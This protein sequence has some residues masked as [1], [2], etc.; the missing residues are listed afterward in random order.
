MLPPVDVRVAICGFVWKKWINRPPGTL[1][2]LSE[3]IWQKQPS[4][5]LAGSAGQPKME[6][7]PEVAGRVEM[8]AG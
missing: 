4:T 1:L 8:C 6:R 3:V 7:K 5:M 2:A